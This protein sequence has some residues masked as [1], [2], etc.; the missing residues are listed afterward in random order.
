MGSI[1]EIAEGAHVDVWLTNFY[2]PDR[3]VRELNS[4][5]E[6]GV[7]RD[8]RLIPVFRSKHLVAGLPLRSWAKE[9]RF[10]ISA[11]LQHRSP[12]YDTIIVHTDAQTHDRIPLS[13]LLVPGGHKICAYPVAV[14][15]P[16]PPPK[17]ENALEAKQ[18][19]I[20][21]QERVWHFARTLKNWLRFHIRMKINSFFVGQMARL[22]LGRNSRALTSRTA[23]AG[24]LIDCVYVVSREVDHQR[25]RAEFPRINSVVAFFPP[26]KVL[27]ASPQDQ[28]RLL[29]LLDL[30]ERDTDGALWLQA[31]RDLN[32]LFSFSEVDLRAHPRDTSSLLAEIAQL[33]QSEL[34]LTVTVSS[35]LSLSQAASQVGYI[36]GNRSSSVEGCVDAAAWMSHSVKILK[37]QKAGTS[38]DD[39]SGRHTTHEMSFQQ[40]WPM[41]AST[42]SLQETS[43][44]PPHSMNPNFAEFVARLCINPP[45]RT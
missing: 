38:C 23:F 4:W 20:Q 44:P 45:H 19:H 35:A 3:V 36:L 24:D 10:W 7:I 34:G 1:P 8:Y 18:V 29:V 12:G 2:V 30:R 43:F 26:P 42:D 14:P 5:K 16:E 21:V 17:P 37:F 40:L 31:I 32:T 13:R 9:S 11:L 33:V 25:I 6:S 22:F 15:F 27:T 41:R 39:D 28:Q